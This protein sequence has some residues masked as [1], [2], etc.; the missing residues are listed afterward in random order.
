MLISKR[1]VIAL[2]SGFMILGAGVCASAVEM[3]LAGIKL[4]SPAASVLK[5]YGNPTR[6]TVAT[7][8]V[9][10]ATMG[11]PGQGG[12]MPGGAQ[13]TMSE[14][15][16]APQTGGLGPMASAFGSSPAPSGAYSPNYSSNYSGYSSDSLPGITGL[17]PPGMQGSSMIPGQRGLPNMNGLPGNPIEGQPVLVEQE[18]TWTYDLQD[19]TT[20]EFIISGSGRVV[21]ITVGGDQAFTLSKTSKGIKLGNYYKDVIFKYGYPESQS[22]VGRFLRASYA[23]KQRCVFTFLGKKLVGITIALKPEGEE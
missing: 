16:G 6:I 13:G 4:S 17:T 18:V 8:Q 7:T 14:I 15:M 23:D 22:Q 19:G 12:M 2:I 9:T 1:A 20:V 10:I 3:N 5:K 21:Q 11:I